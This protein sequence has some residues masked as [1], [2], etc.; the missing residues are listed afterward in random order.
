MSPNTVHENRGRRVTDKP[1]AVLDHAVRMERLE[2]DQRL[3]ASQMKNSI[4]ALN[5]TL[6]NIQLESRA[7]VNQLAQLTGLQGAHDSNKVAI[8]EV[9]KSVGELNTRLEEWFDDFDQRQDRR[10][11]EY[12]ANRD[13]WRRE[14]EAENEDVKR[15]TD[16]EIRSL[17]ETIIRAI[18]FSSAIGALGGVIVGGFLWV[19][20]GRFT[21]IEEDTKD[22]TARI[23]STTARTREVVDN[24]NAELVDIKLY[25]ARGGR[26]PEEPYIPKSQRKEDGNES[27]PGK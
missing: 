12:E 3:L 22:D 10:W 25:L 20:N 6:S 23:E 27:K 11:R 7:M 19:L 5:S 13:Q 1:G 8:D 21:D 17:R 24:L 4:D 9:K 26:I 18:G 14:H 2:G 16:K 15:E